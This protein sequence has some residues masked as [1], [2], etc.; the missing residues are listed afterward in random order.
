MKPEAELI[1]VM[2]RCSGEIKSLRAEIAR[3]QPKADAYDKLSIVLNLLPRQSQAY[4]EDLAWR[5]DQRIAELS[6]QP[7]PEPAE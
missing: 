6:K 2:K 3:L 7:E 1:E 5:L 4:G